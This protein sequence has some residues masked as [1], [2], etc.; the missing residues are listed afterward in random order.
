M[1]A[2]LSS[3][4]A[5]RWQRSWDRLEE[6]YVPHREEQIAA[7]L[8]VVEAVVGVDPVVIDLGCGTGTATLRLLE[9]LPMATA[10]GVDVD[11]VLLAI[12]EATFAGDDRVQIVTADLRQPGWLNVLPSSPV[13][14]V[15]TVTALHWLTEQTVE[16]LY[17]DL[18]ALVRPGGVFLHAEVIPLTGLRSILADLSRLRS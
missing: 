6:H 10:I 11:P 13:D 14:A 16:R 2:P 18:A 3:E 17:R 12:A 7:V 1:P 5:E 4:T 15:V 8:E 9:R